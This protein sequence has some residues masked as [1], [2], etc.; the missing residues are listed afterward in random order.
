MVESLRLFD[1]ICNSRWFF[2]TSMI[3]FL[4]KK[5]LFE[6]KIKRSNITPAF[7]EYKGAQTYDDCIKYIRQKFEEANTNRKKTIFVHETCATDTNQVQIILESV[8]SMIIQ[9]NLHKSGLY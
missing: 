5:D 3:L 8:I 1:S 4:N 9:A 2:E 6:Q 7:P